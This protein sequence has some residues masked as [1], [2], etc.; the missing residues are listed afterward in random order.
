VRRYLQLFPRCEI[1]SFEPNADAFGDLAKEAGSDGRVFPHPFAL[2]DTAGSRQMYVHPRL[3][4][5]NSLYNRP[6]HGTAYYPTGGWLSAG[7]V[8]ETQTVDAFCERACISR[9]DIMKIDVQGAELL[10]LKGASAMLR[11][12][13]ID[14]IF[15][16]VMFVP[17]YEGAPLY[18]EVA[19]FLGTHG[20]LLYGVY[21]MHHADDGQLCQADALFLSSSLRRMRLQSA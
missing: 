10:V 21:E 9:I 18:H 4:A 15:A 2:A 12:E 20:Y 8:V 13:A 11:R 14:L 6:S 17:H 16:E 3:D 7:P 19:T 1:H 5:T